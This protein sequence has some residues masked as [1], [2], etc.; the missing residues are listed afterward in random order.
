VV[1]VKSM[2]G[3]CE[4]NLLKERCWIMDA[5]LLNMRLHGRIAMSPSID[6]STKLNI[7]L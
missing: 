5:V 1:L 7:N 6:K 4:L 3:K 2:D